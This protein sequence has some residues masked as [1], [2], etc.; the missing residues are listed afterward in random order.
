MNTP[1]DTERDL[2]IELL[3][4]DRAL[5]IRDLRRLDQRLAYEPIKMVLFALGFAGVVTMA[6]AVI[7]LKL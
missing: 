3:R 6:L 2:R 7:L 5:K 1:D 4:L